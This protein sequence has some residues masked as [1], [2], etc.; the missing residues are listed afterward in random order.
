M[1]QNRAS[2]RYSEK[3]THTEKERKR[4]R[5]R[6]RMCKRVREISRENERVELR[7]AKQKAEKEKPMIYDL[8]SVRVV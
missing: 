3:A 1:Q 7:Q 2:K 4:K 6:E 8:N 5:D